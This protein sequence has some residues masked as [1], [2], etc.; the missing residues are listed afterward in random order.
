MHERSLSPFGFKP[1]MPT[2]LPSAAAGEGGL[3][4]KI[5]ARSMLPGASC[6]KT[7]HH[8]FPAGEGVTRENGGRVGSAR[9]VGVGFG[10]WSQF[11][12]ASR[13]EE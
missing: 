2:S 11:A 4:G 1:W 3:R 5:H 8:G 9:G 13:C 12:A 10:P 6:R 7:H